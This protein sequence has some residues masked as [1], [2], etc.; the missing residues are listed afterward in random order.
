MAGRFIPTVERESIDFMCVYI[1][2]KIYLLIFFPFRDRNVA[3][4]LPS[5][6]DEYGLTSFTQFGTGSS[7]TLGASL[8]DLL[9]SS[10]SHQSM[11][12]GMLYAHMI[13]SP[14]RKYNRD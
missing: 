6:Y 7:C 4:K 12:N 2:S 11:S 3:S 13:P 10:S 1:G 5:R 8:P 9:T 14:A